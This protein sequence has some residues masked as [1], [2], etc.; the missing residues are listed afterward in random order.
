M[1]GLPAKSFVFSLI[2][3]VSVLSFASA[4]IASAQA[5]P[6]IDSVTRDGCV[7]TIV[8]TTYELGLHTLAIWDDGAVIHSADFDA[9]TSPQQFTTTY[10]ISSP[11]GQQAVGYAYVVTSPTGQVSNDTVFSDRFQIPADVAQECFERFGQ[12]GCNLNTPSGSVVGALTKPTLTY[13]APDLSKELD[14][15]LILGTDPTNKTWWVLGQDAT[16]SFY[17]IAIVCDVY[18][19]VPVDAMGPN[20]DA[21]WHGT[22]LP[23][24]VVK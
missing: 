18:V 16:H 1:K 20:Y 19:W 12:V 21:V 7:L 13:W 8:F 10:T 22:P 11:V 5:I 2:V 15:R 9:T 14:P 6:T 17:K 4:G 3:I 24:R 23:T